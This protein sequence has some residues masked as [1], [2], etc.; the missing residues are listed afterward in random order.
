MRRFLLAV[1]AFLGLTGLVFVVFFTAS[2]YRVKDQSYFTSLSDFVF[3]IGAANARVLKL[4]P[5]ELTDRQYER[6]MAHSR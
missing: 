4:D 2:D 6:V 5:P 1:G 3:M